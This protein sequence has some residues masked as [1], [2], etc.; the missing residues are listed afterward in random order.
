MRT[1]QRRAR[2]VQSGTVPDACGPIPDRCRHVTG[3]RT[4]PV[5][6]VVL[7]AILG[8]ASHH[9]TADPSRA[10]PRPPDRTPPR[11]ACCRVHVPHGSAG[12]RAWP[13]HRARAPATLVLLLTVDQLRGDYLARFETQLGGGLGRLA[14]G[15]AFF[16]NAFH[17]HALTETAP[18]HASAWSGRHAAGAGIPS[19]ERGVPDTGARLLDAAGEG[20][21]PHR[22]RGTTLFDWLR[23][24]GAAR[25]LSVSRKDRSAILAI[26]QARESV[27][28][29]AEEG[30][31]TTSTYYSQA[32]PDWVRAFNARRLPERMA[33]RQWT[34]LLP[35]SAYPE[36][37]AQPREAGGQ[38]YTFPHTLPVDSTQ[39]ARTLMDSAVR[40][41]LQA[42]G[43]PPGAFR[44]EGATLWGSG[45][46]WRPQVWIRTR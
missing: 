13:V 12:L 31:F 2:D 1:V 38:G 22:F 16:P 42:R 44:L 4:D 27:Y 8:A 25:A 45:R 29:F 21:S 32:L 39:A 15:G 24:R 10:P 37:D 17:D 41:A 14:R 7:P 11:L 18:G 23:A 34:P 6:S 43:I 40:Q 26:G 36:P 20:A 19:N 35:D 33:G 5:P 30:R 46:P 3:L 9:E 28:W